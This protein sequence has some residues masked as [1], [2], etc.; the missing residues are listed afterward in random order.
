MT[1]CKFEFFDSSPLYVVHLGTMPHVLV[2][3][4]HNPLLAWRHLWM[5]PFSYVRNGNL[6]QKVLTLFY[7]L[8]P[9]S[10]YLKLDSVM[11]TSL[12]LFE[13]KMNYKNWRERNLYFLFCLSLWYW[14]SFIFKIYIRI[15]KLYF[16]K[17]FKYLK[18]KRTTLI[19]CLYEGNFFLTKHL[20]SNWNNS[21]IQI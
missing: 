5:V 6:S 1:S 11:W 13:N 16:T 8:F 19:Q 18:Y 7:F 4:N 14:F 20:R 3:H 12:F 21:K 2:S 9:A 17:T 10:S 15:N